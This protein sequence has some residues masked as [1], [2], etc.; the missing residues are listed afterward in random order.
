MGLQAKLS[1]GQPGERSRQGA[2]HGGQLVVQPKRMMEQRRAQPLTGD[3]VTYGESMRAE[4]SQ[5]ENKTGLPDRLKAGIEHLSG[6]AM[7][8]VRVHYNSQKPA[9]LQALAYAQGTEIHVGP[10]QE[11]HL[12]HEA[13][14]VVQQKQG[15]VKPTKISDIKINVNVEERL[16]KEADQKGELAKGFQPHTDSRGSA[17]DHELTRE[18]THTKP[19]IQPSIHINSRDYTP[20]EST[21]DENP[22]NSLIWSWHKDRKPRN[23]A[24]FPKLIK[25][26][27]TAIID[28]QKAKQL[29]QARDLLNKAEIRHGGYA[30]EAY[31][32]ESAVKVYQSL[33]YNKP[34]TILEQLR[35]RTWTCREGALMLI[36]LSA[37]DQQKKDWLENHINTMP[38]GTTNFGSPLETLLDNV[39]RKKAVAYKGES[40]PGDIINIYGTIH[41]VV[42]AGAGQVFSLNGGKKFQLV[43]LKEEVSSM[44]AESTDLIKIEY[45]KKWYNYGLGHNTEW[46]ADSTN[47]DALYNASTIA[48]IPGL[49]EAK[50][51]TDPRKVCTI[52][53][54][55]TITADLDQKV[56]S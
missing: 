32:D 21:K 50:F 49:P 13:W 45:I 10:G 26:A 47:I 46:G 53:T 31:L 27:E 52:T 12:P 37:S 16:E 7:D 19:I 1:F 54:A 42:S 14:H 41:T 44:W 28:P 38:H 4:R 40:R 9:Q 34:K 6:Y 36:L 51:F 33:V 3:S 30:H 43:D 23:F 56:T 24:S 55:K 39:M 8:D 35:K 20:R 48:Q 5:K 11:K 22:L 2:N 25:A 29:S 17:I 15:R 18:V